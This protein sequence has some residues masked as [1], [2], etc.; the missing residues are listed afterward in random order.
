MNIIKFHETIPSIPLICG[1]KFLPFST[2]QMLKRCFVLIKMEF[3]LCIRLIEMDVNDASIYQVYQY[4]V[5][6]SITDY[7]N[8]NNN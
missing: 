5:K 2:D 8:E 1:D 3:Y 7:F 6:K 4:I